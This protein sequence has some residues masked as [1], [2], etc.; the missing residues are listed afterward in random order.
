MADDAITQTEDTPA[1]PPTASPPAPVAQ[2]PSAHGDGVMV[3]FF[4]ADDLA[5]KLAIPDGEPAEG[6]HCTLAFFGKRADLPTDFTEKAGPAIAEVAEKWAPIAGVI[7]GAGVFNASKTSD[8]M[9]VLYA[10]PDC[11]GLV[12]F[13]QEVLSA[14]EAA[15]GVRAKRTHGWTPHVTLAYVESPAVSLEVETADLRFDEVA[16][17][18]GNSAE[19]YPLSGSYVEKRRLKISDDGGWT[20]RVEIT[21]RD[22]AQM[23]VFGFALEATD[24]NGN[25]TSD[26][27]A[28][29]ISEDEMAETAFD[30]AA[31]SGTG[32]AMHKP[33]D[34]GF[35]P[36]TA[37]MITSVPLTQEIR[38][39][40][41]LPP[42]PGRWFVG[43][44]I[45]DREV[46]G[47]VQSGELRE[48]SVKGSARRE[49]VAV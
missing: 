19:S 48:L 6:L 40:A 18:V 11:P 37:Y 41:E 32:G 10:S 45:T 38:K 14:V 8:E 30:Y 4:V 25:E 7:G 9:S 24:A 15:T 16:L 26:Y 20:A 42:G 28:E 3:A 17:A 21:K 23:R 47:R 12:E 43:L 29:V 36:D 34:P 2:E 39:A 27:A 46:W 49:A 5:T 33:S 44:Q 22:D 31:N 13:R 35:A 1:A